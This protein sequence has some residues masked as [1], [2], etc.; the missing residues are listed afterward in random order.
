MTVVTGGYGAQVLRPLLAYEGW[1]A[2]KGPVRLLA[3]END[4]FGGTIA[5]TGLLTGQDVARALGQQPERQRFLLPDVCLSRGRF[6]DDWSLDDLPRQV[7]VVPT[8]GAALRQALG[9]RP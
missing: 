1:L 8:D 6:L 9:G 4:F 7:E 2:P 3:V 5:V